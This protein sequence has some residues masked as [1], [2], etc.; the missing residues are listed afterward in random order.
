[1]KERVLVFSIILL[2][3]SFSL[4][5]DGAQEK[6]PA[7][8]AASAEAAPAAA[9]AAKVEI[10]YYDWQ[11]TEEP[12][13]TIIRQIIADFEKENPNIKVSLQ[14]V[15]TAQRIDK[16]VTLIM[17]NQAPDVA[18]I[19][20]QDYSK[21]VGMKAI[22]GLDGYLAKD[23]QLKANI[24]PSMA[25]LVN[26]S[27]VQY[28]I[29]RFAT[30]NGLMYNG[31]HFRDAGLDPARS[32]KEWPE[33][34]ADAKKLTRDSS[35]SGKVDRWAY[36][37]LGAK[38][39]SL[40]NR[41]WPWVWSAGGD[42]LN[43]AMDKVVLDTPEAVAAMK[44]YTDL[45]RVY[46]VVPPGVLDVDYPASTNSFIQG[47]TSM[48]CD[49]PW[50][51]ASLKQQ[52]PTLELKIA[53]MPAAPG[54]Q[55]TMLGGGTGLSIA[56]QSRNPDSAWKLI[57]YLSN[58]EN[59]WKYSSGGSNLPTRVDTAAKMAREGSAEMGAFAGLLSQTK[60]LPPIPQFSQIGTLL[61]E[62]VQFVFLGQKTAEEAS[63]S[64]TDRANALLKR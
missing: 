9:P 52:N 18:H 27:G 34:I 64:L 57:Q 54:H 46:K 38:N 32:P 61:A 55:A 19:S 50:V 3:A 13:G 47:K 24:I 22:M 10:S 33:F 49:G 30:V 45:D 14:P 6:R 39:L 23:A 21:V 43:P 11:L 15:P 63:R 8:P 16:L 5:A 51:L 25:A 44:M 40:H 26:F 17:G 29:P 37:L 35:G 31:A 20:A 4:F 62:E 1:M 60:A 56:A 28:G 41:Y 53:A 2:L 42:I 36:S 7:A 12:S 48:M 58:A 59:Y